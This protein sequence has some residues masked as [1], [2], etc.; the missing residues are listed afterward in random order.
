MFFGWAKSEVDLHRA[1]WDPE[2]GHLD[3]PLGFH[4]SDLF[5]LLREDPT[6]LDVASWI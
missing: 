5:C 1:L 2:F 6:L 3:L 4:K